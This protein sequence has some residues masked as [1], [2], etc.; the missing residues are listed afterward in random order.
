MIINETYYFSITCDI[1]NY[2]TDISNIEVYCIVINL[3]CLSM[4][5]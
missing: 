1:V 5:V 3:H 2:R 4:F